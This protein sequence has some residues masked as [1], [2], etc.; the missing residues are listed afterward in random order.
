[1]IIGSKIF[2]KEIVQNSLDWAQKNIENAS[3]GSIF[4]ADKHVTTHG[5]LGRKWIFDKDQLVVT[6]LLKPSVLNSIQKQILGLRLNQL[7]MAIS[8]GIVESLNKYSISLKWPNDFYF[9]NKK[10]GGVLAKTV[11]YED[12]IK[13]VIFGFA[14]N[15]N[16]NNNIPIL[17]NKLYEAISLKKIAGQKLDKEFLFYEILKSIDNFYQ[18]WMNC[19]YE[20]IFKKWK[21]AQ[22]YIGKSVIIHKQYDEMIEGKFIDVTEYGNML[23]K[24]KNN[25]LEIPVF[26]VENIL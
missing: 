18:Y 2:Y 11:W 12:S 13:A 10:V 24:T 17:N 19:K 3:D 9:N 1:M 16:N 22:A 21:Q 20:D 7:N 14:L 4:M 25:L 5:R 6:I 23:L 26:T 15:V 8:L